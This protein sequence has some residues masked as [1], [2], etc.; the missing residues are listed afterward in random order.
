MAK[1]PRVAKAVRKEKKP[2]QDKQ[3]QLLPPKI[4][5]VDKDSA[6]IGVQEKVVVPAER[7]K[8]VPHEL[9][10][11]VEAL[12]VRVSNLEAELRALKK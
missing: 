9:I 8:L 3:E 5:E 6:I 4:V 2:K 7:K 11:T 1:E 12:L 10:Q